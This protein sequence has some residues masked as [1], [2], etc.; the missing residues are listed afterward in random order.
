MSGFR[1]ESFSATIGW[2]A[3]ESE[4]P[5][6]LKKWLFS[7]SRLPSSPPWWAV[8]AFGGAWN[9]FGGVWWAACACFAGATAL[10]FVLGPNR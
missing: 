5:M 10:L 9:A 1:K 3:E 6:G 8:F 2:A 4:V 7:P